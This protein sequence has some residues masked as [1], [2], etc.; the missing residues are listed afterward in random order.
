MKRLI[1]LT[2]IVMMAMVWAA[3]P[4]YGKIPRRE[5]NALKA[6]FDA[7][8]G[9]RWD[10]GGERWKG[11]PGTEN[12]WYGVT[13]NKSNTSVLKIELRN[14]N[15]SGVLPAELSDLKNLGSLILSDNG[16]R[17]IHPD[18][19][20]LKKLH[21]LDLSNNRLS[22]TIPAWI[23][24]LRGLRKLD[25]RYNR[26]SG[27]IPAWI[28]NLKNLE[29]LLL[30]GNMLSGPIP[31]EL[32]RLS[33]LKILRLGHN[34]LTGEIPSSMG[35]LTGLADNKSNF[36]WNG[37]YTSDASLAG[38]LEIKQA[39]RNWQSTQTTA[40]EEIQATSADKIFINL[41]W[42]PIL[43]KT[44][45]G[46]YRVYYSDKKGG[47]YEK[48]AGVTADKITA[49]LKV[50]E[51]EPST[52]Y[53]FQVQAWTSPHGS[54]RNRIESGFSA[55]FAA[56]TRGTTISGG[57]KNIYGSAEP[58]VGITA[59]NKGGKALTDANGEYHLSVVPG[60]SGNVTP[61]KKG[62]DF[63]PAVLEY[64]KVTGDRES[65]DYTADPLTKISGRV[66]DAAGGSTAGVTFTFTDE[67]GKETGAVATDVQ[68]N[69]TFAVP[70]DWTGTVTPV[71]IGHMFEP[72]SREYS[73]VTGA[74]PGQGYRSHRL[75]EI[76]GRVKDKRGKVMPG[77]TLTFLGKEKDTAAVK[78][79]TGENGEYT[80]MFE[81][82]WAGLVKP[83]KSG[84]LFYPSRKVY[85]SLTLDNVKTAENYRAELKTRFFFS[86]GGNQVL[87]AE[88]RFGDIYG[89][90]MLTPR[91][92]AGFRITRSLYLWGGYDFSSKSGTIPVFDGPAKWREQSLSL[93]LGYYRN[94]SISFDYRIGL[95]ASFI[96]YSEEAFEE[97]V[98]GRAVGILLDA[99]WIYKFS[100]RF[101]S[102]F[103]L[104]YLFASDTAADGLDTDL[105][106]FRIGAG[107]GVKF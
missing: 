11:R 8:N 21:T 96:G 23:G 107:L 6:L 18:A 29:V 9:P 99:A 51:L 44:D 70:Y 92:S 15:V 12:T 3:A 60:W 31:E 93:G 72:A 95:G 45:S 86:V 1:S 49:G 27:G 43:Y 83:A 84:Y 67:Q 82:D 74:E 7:A 101:F 13:C 97:E 85:K 88:A 79:E 2:I 52:T 90:G 41:A 81:K 54:N 39:G 87:P 68:G 19:G 40:P 34:R 24:Q 17:E 73:T 71:K 89:S 76:G 33:K 59:S 10:K 106:G 78:L 38:F 50:E 65:Q 30:D 14:N 47:P 42:Q 5:S 35:K 4:M 105:G 37:L 91:L 56:A 22:G 64:L 36:K 28:G 16:L 100:D 103:T 62:F 48:I 26:L 20:K 46:G 94:L 58:G 75:P 98:S 32:G 77:V 102:E 66:K 53:Y 57:I 69:Y 55:E 80:K 25:L 63:S 61:A 104:G